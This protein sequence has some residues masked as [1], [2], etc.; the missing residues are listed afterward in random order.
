MKSSKLT[1]ILSVLLILAL[2]LGGCGNTN[3]Q[4]SSIVNNV[5]SEINTDL[6]TA[7]SSEYVIACLNN[8][9][10]ITGIEL[11]DLSENSS[12]SSSGLDK[13]TASVFFSSSLVDEY[14][15]SKSVLE[16]GTSGGGSIDIFTTVEDAQNRNEYLDGFDG[17]LL[18]SGYHTVVGTLVIRTSKHLSE[19]EQA[20]FESSIVTVLTSGEVDPNNLTATATET[21]EATIIIE[22]ASETVPTT[23]PTEPPVYAPISSDDYMGM[24]YEDVIALFKNAGFTNISAVEYPTTS[25]PMVGYQNGYVGGLQVNDSHT[26]DTNTPYSADVPVLIN[27]ATWPER[28]ENSTFAVHYIDVGQADAALVLCDGKAMLIDGGNAEDSNLIFSY[29]KTHNIDHLDYI[30]CT[31]A[32]EDHV[33]GLAG[34]LN[35][36]SVGTAYCPVTSYDSRAF[37]SFV[38]YLGN[39]GVN[40]TVPSHSDSF[41]LGSAECQ[42]LGPIYSSSEPNNTSLVIKIIYGN[43]SFLFTGDAERDEEQDILNAGYD[44]SCTVLKVGHHGSDTSTSYVW[45]RSAAPSYAVI[46]VGEGNSYGHPTEDVLSRLRDADVITFRTDMQGD[47]IC[48]SDGNTVTFDVERNA[49]ADT[50]AN[51]GAGSHQETEPVAVAP[52]ITDSEDTGTDY[53]GNKNTKKFHYDWCSSVDQ[54]KESNK[55]YYTGTRYEMIAKG[56]EPCKRCDP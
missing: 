38:K 39:Q 29:L 23:S 16:N 33:G 2:L 44:I 8:V 35:Y 1:R 52:V 56:Y 50:L 11:D 54:M 55:F 22:T 20:A 4:R 30:V 32:H 14:D 19:E 17:G 27:Y 9:D 43:T 47:I 40:I 53:I 31:H 48:S 21:T 13:A 34:A 12:I 51:A 3:T 24:Y 25:D 42:V 37:E 15:P 7:P 6:I 49:D 28:P 5:Y 45:L 26:F 10:T 18:D 46:S 41:T 36:A